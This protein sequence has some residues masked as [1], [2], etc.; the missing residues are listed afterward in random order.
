MPI[1]H[2]LPPTPG[3]KIGWESGAP[4]DTSIVELVERGGGF[5]DLADR[6]AFDHGVTVGRS[7]VYL[8]FLR[9]DYDTAVFQAFKEVEISVRNASRLGNDRLG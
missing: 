3:W 5:N 1:L 7:G 4:L 6:Q 9:G 8:M 2:R